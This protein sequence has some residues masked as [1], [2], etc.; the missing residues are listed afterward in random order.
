MIYDSDL[1]IAGS[2]D[3]ATLNEIKHLIYM[4]GNEV[5]KSKENRWQSGK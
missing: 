1:K 3:Y 2:I 4:I 5:L